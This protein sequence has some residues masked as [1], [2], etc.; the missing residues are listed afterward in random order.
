MAD[1]S[2]FNGEPIAIIYVENDIWLRIKDYKN[3]LNTGAKNGVSALSYEKE[4]LL[5]NV[6]GFVDK[7]FGKAGNKEK[8]YKEIE[9]YA[10]DLRTG[11]GAK[12]QESEY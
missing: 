4:R 2:T 5:R 8:L 6:K 12:V 7:K 9:K 1:L 3:V 11:T 10:D